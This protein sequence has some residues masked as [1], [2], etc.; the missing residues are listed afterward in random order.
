LKEPVELRV[1]RRHG[2]FRMQLGIARSRRELGVLEDRKKVLR[3]LADRGEWDVLDAVKEGRASAEEVERLIDQLGIDNYRSRFVL[4]P[5]A[6]DAPTLRAHMATW[7]ATIQK[8]STKKAYGRALPW[9]LDYE[10]DGVK[11]GERPWPKIA[12]HTIR[13]LK[14]SLEHSINSVRLYM[15]AW[16]SF[17]SWAIEREQSEAEEQ[18]REPLLTANP[19]QQAKAWSPIERTRHRFLT[20]AEFRTLLTKSAPAMRPQYATLILCG[21]RI[22]EFMH[23]P[24]A[25]VH[26]PSHIHIG[27]WGTWAPKGYPR[28]KH[29]VRDVPLHRELGPMLEE[30]AATQGDGPAFFVNPNTGQGWSYVG[31]T[32]RMARD[33]EAAGMIYGQWSRAGGKLER[34]REGVTP[35]TFRHTLASWL[36]Q[37][38]V[39]L[40][41]IAAILGDTV[42]TVEKHYAHL[43]PTDLDQS[44]N[45]V[46]F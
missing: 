7:L 39:Q 24:P 40:M 19:V 37:K 41:K 28:Y 33:I 21:L 13:D 5:P 6:P 14:A 9:L 1:R 34:S 45:R 4:A 26:L 25:H 11:L 18:G 32:K 2:S 36:A 31:F 42:E 23:L 43:V 35:H 27:P 29:G 20:L 17:Y 8:P 3:R 12:R 10:V 46:G 44:V 22:E 15:G 16:S 38:D 30:Y